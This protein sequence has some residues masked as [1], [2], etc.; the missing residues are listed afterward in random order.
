MKKMF[1]D[2][3]EREKLVLALLFLL[4]FIVRLVF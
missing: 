1:D 2:M 4:L 3:E